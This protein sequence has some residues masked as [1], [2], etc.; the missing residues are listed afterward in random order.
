[1][2]SASYAF[3]LGDG[4]NDQTEVVVEAKNYN[5]AKKL[6]ESL[7]KGSKVKLGELRRVV[8]SRLMVNQQNV[9]ERR[10]FVEERQIDV[11]HSGELTE[12]RID[13]GTKK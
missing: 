1:M 6:A 5:E 2:E 11:K 10:M 13:G 12:I 8:D 4:Y 3:K 7:L 9:V